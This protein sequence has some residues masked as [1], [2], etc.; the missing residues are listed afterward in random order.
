MVTRVKPRYLK[1]KSNLNKTALLENLGCSKNLVKSEAICSVLLNSGYALLSTKDLSNLADL[2]IINTCGFIKSARLEAESTIENI[3]SFLKKEGS[4]VVVGCYASR[5]A[6]ELQK[7]Y[8]QCIILDNLDPVEGIVQFLKQTNN[9]LNQ[10]IISTGY[11]AYLEISTG[12]EKSCSY[13]LIPSIQGPLKSKS[14]QKVIDE[15]K[16]VVELNPVKEIVL[17]AQ[18]T[19]AYGKDITPT[20]SLLK[21]IDSLSRINNLEWIRLLYFY[22]QKP[23][24][25]LKEILSIDKVVPYLDIP[26]QHFS[27]KILK[28]MNRPSNLS[29]FLDQLF[30]FKQKNPLLTLRSTF[31]V[32]FPGETEE[33]YQLLVKGLH[34]YPF[35][36]AGFFAYSREKETAS[37]LLPHQVHS[38]TKQKRLR[39]AYRIQETIS[40]RENQ[41][42]VG[43]E[44]PVLLEYFDTE[45]QH[46]IGRTYRE[47]P[48]IDPLVIV[49][50]NPFRLKRKMGT[51]QSMKITETTAYQVQ[52]ILA[53]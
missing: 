43:H 37:D 9:E 41:K 24:S 25:Q 53:A 23:F 50:G 20:L 39:E 11:Y 52:G 19:A 44:M 48:E 28:L 46:A 14:L 4:L 36:R 27:P 12:C 51:I 35:D 16:K 45:K 10:R 13:C 26:L 31:M 34:Q 40:L 3:Q 6:E 38:S 1:N 32:G 18:D 47:A 8:P 49:K 30:N 42:W 21:L 7:K 29:P 5:F 33:D 22:P 17:I 2:I 15:A